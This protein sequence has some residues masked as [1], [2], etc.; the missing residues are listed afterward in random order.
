MQV[1]NL[2]RKK[3]LK[4]YTF[5]KYHTSNAIRIANEYWNNRNWKLQMKLKA[6]Y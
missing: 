1:H 3:S 6:S 5:K 4:E 2:I